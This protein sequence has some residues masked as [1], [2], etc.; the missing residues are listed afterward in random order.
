MI[1]RFVRNNN[2]GPPQSDGVRDRDMQPAAPQRDL[3]AVVVHRCQEW[4][5]NVSR[6]PT[7]P[8]WPASSAVDRRGCELRPPRLSDHRPSAP[9]LG[10]RCAIA[11]RHRGKFPGKNYG[12]S[13]GFSPCLTP[14]TRKRS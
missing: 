14:K 7:A 2:D 3:L 1:T 13:R 12:F 8:R 9:S 10:P 11:T 6:K 5:V 4:E